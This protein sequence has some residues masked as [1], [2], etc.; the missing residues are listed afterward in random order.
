MWHSVH[1][2]NGVCIHLTAVLEKYTG[3]D[4]LS[5][6]W[7]FFCFFFDKL[8]TVCRLN[9]RSIRLCHIILLPGFY[10]HSWLWQSSF[11]VSLWEDWLFPAGH[12]LKRAEWRS[13]VGSSQGPTSAKYEVL[14]SQLIVCPLDRHFFCSLRLVH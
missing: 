10:G 9:R 5:T 7:L 1:L 8:L 6:H 2:W 14:L 12:K 3:C 4:W 11:P 13:S